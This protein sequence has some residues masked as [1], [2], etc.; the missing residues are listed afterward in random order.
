VTQHVSIGLHQ[1]KLQLLKNS[2]MAQ[3]SLRQSFGEASKSNEQQVFNSDLCEALLSA[4]I[5]LTNLNNS[6]LKT[7]LE[8]YCQKNIPDESTL[9]KSYVI[10]IYTSVR[11]AFFGK[12]Q[13][14]SRNPHHGRATPGV[15]V[16]SGWSLGLVNHNYHCTV[17]IR[18]IETR[19]CLSCIWT[20]LRIYLYFI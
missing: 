14:R 17:K 11:Y 19:G 1:G 20:Y 2:K 6:N 8:K 13:R 10:G 4:N 7:F 15:R 9:R 18:E 3:Q 5:P 12:R 16:L